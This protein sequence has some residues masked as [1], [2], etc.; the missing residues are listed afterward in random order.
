M[1][2][3]Y[4][5]LATGISDWMCINS[6]VRSRNWLI[7][8]TE[9]PRFGRDMKPLKA[10]IT[11]GCYTDKTPVHERGVRWQIQKRDSGGRAGVL[12]L[13]FRPGFFVFPSCRVFAFRAAPVSD[14]QRATSPLHG[15]ARYVS[16]IS[17]VYV[18][19]ITRAN[20]YHVSTATKVSHSQPPLH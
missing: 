13:P 11:L 19:F 17:S 15:V 10:I 20:A 18:S 16:S 8:S 1:E 5:T 4:R 7:G 6:R 2:D 14:V 9:A 3:G 12:K